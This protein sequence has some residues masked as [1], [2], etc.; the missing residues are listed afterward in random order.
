MTTTS[1][2]VMHFPSR[3]NASRLGRIIV[4][5]T[6]AA[7]LAACSAIRLGYGSIESLAYWWLD[8]YVDFDE[9]Q[10]PLVRE[11][12]ARLH[13][14]HRREELPRI[15][16][17]LHR[18]E[19]L[20][21]GDI[22]PE[23][24]CALVDDLRE[25][26]LALA[27]QAEPAVVALAT[28][29]HPEQLRHIRAKYRKTNAKYRDEWL[30]LAPEDLREKRFD[31]F[32]QRAEMIY[33]DL[34]EPQREALRR[35][36]QQAPFDAAFVLAERQRRQRDL[37]Q[38]LLRVTQPGV[39]FESA[40]GLMRAYLDRAITPPDAKARAQQ[41][42]MIQAGCHQFAV[43]HASTTVEQRERAVRRLRAYQ[44]DV[45]ELSADQ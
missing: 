23:Q 28:S 11:D 40:R 8:S 22:R 34:D 1:I 24:A 30:S 15:G 31:Q 44:R 20:M 14:W 21:P 45:A 25:R 3:L 33:G 27:A 9:Q 10:G 12:L 5:L 43:L 17:M 2:A 26:G 42:A 7:G 35:D 38:T 4:L 39:S 18:M 13:A 37:L 41:E 29:L 16:Q 19:E 36:M 6:L 32:V